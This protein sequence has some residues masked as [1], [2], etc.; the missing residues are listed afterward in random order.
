[1]EEPDIQFG[2]VKRGVKRSWY[3]DEEQTVLETEAERERKREGSEGKNERNLS[4]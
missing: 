2:T 1:M 3:G 4:T